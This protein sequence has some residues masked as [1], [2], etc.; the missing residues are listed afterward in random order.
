MVLASIGEQASTALF[1]AS[2]S[3]LTFC[4]STSS[5]HF[6]KTLVECLFNVMVIP[7]RKRHFEKYIF[8]RGNGFKKTMKLEQNTNKISWGI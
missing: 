1:F 4:Q 2:T 3:T 7:T 8:V 6:E 5:E